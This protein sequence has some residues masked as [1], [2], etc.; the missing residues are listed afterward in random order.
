MA[1]PPP[2]EPMN[3]WYLGILTPFL[4][5]NIYD[6]IKN[7]SFGRAGSCKPIDGL[8]HVTANGEIP[9][10][11]NCGCRIIIP[12]H[13]ECQVA[14]IATQPIWEEKFACIPLKHNSEPVDFFHKVCSERAPSDCSD[15]ETLQY[16]GIGSSS[17]QVDNLSKAFKN[18]HHST[19]ITTAL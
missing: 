4:T 5:Q 19:A 12:R 11:Q 16:L 8:V 10:Y 7:V 18:K 1:V 13:Y 3:E 2:L 9:V 6:I 15:D 14:I 17:I